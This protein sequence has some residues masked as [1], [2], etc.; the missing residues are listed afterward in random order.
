MKGQITQDKACWKWKK[1]LKQ[2][3]INISFPAQASDFTLKIFSSM[4]SDKVYDIYILAHTSNRVFSKRSWKH[5][6][7]CLNSLTRQILIKKKKKEG[8]DLLSLHHQEVNSIYFLSAL[9]K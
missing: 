5:A 1:R 9:P 8:Q 4:V 3:Y 6:N 2:I 7:F